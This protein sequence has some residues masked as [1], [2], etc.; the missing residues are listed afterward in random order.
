MTY[1]T[2]VCPTEFTYI[3]LNNHLVNFS[4]AWYKKIDYVKS[5]TESEDGPKRPKQ[6]KVNFI[7]HLENDEAF[8]VMPV[9]AT[10]KLEINPITRH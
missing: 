4:K 5:A 1:Y 3:I 8:N 9:A 2:N 6:S 10:I 7:Q